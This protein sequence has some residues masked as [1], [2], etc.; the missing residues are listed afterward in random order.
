MVLTRSANGVFFAS[1]SRRVLA[2]C[3]L[4][5]GSAA[6]NVV[7]AHADAEELRYWKEVDQEQLIT[8]SGS[9]SDDAGVAG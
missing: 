2:W 5:C 6:A 8:E 7:E 9:D 3:L 4:L 1:N